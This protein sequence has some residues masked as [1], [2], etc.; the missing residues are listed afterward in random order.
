MRSCSLTRVELYLEMFRY[1][2]VIF[3]SNWIWILSARTC[4]FNKHS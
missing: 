1:L 3:K 4:N 2:K